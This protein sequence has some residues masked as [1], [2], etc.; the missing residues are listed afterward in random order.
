MV[1]SIKKE[2]FLSYVK[3]VWTNRNINATEHNAA[4][5]YIQVDWMAVFWKEETYTKRLSIGIPYIIGNILLEIFSKRL[6]NVMLRFLKGNE[7]SYLFNY[8]M[9]VSIK[10]SFCMFS[11]QQL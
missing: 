10:W 3:A 1:Q 9:E 11:Q 4:F 8:A 2:H 6:E 7:I 5:I